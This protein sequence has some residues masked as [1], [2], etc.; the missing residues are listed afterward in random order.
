[1]IDFSSIGSVFM[2][3]KILFYVFCAFFALAFIATS[4]LVYHWIKYSKEMDLRYKI[5]PLIYVVGIL[6]CVMISFSFYM[7]LK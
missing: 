7:M 6:L 2:S 5:M 3:K 1:M 4:A